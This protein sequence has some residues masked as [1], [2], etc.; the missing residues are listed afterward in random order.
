MRLTDERVFAYQGLFKGRVTSI[1]IVYSENVGQ[2]LLSLVANIAAE[3]Q[4]GDGGCTQSR[5]LAL[6]AVLSALSC[7]VIVI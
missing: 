4:V 3:Q 7:F 1:I 6:E 5:I 2:V